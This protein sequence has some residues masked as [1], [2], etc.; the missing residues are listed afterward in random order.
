MPTR[1]PDNGLIDK[2]DLIVEKDVAKVRPIT[3]HDKSNANLIVSVEEVEEDG[4]GG[5]TLGLGC[6]RT[7]Y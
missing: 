6:L 4:C 3:N 7:D 1:H 2:N 5:K